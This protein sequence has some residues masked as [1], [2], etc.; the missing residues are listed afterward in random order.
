[1]YLKKI[2]LC[3]FKSFP[4]R[5]EF[6]F[7]PGMT[8]IVGPNG[9]GKSNVVDALKWILGEQ[10]ARSLRGS[11]ML[12]VIFNG[13][14]TR[15]ALGMA[16][17]TL[18]LAEAGGLRP[19]DAAQGGRDPEEVTVTR[20]LYRSG[21]SE[22]LI[23]GGPCRLRDVRDLLAGTGLSTNAYAV[24]EQGRID[25]LIAA[26]PAERR[27]VFEEAAGIGQWKARKVESERRLERVEQNLARLVDIFEEV[28]KRLRGVRWAAA[29]ARRYVEA[30]DE[31]RRLRVRLVSV[32]YRREGRELAAA[33]DAL[34]EVEGRH[35]LA[36]EG[37]S[38]AAE[39]LRRVE[40][41]GQ[42]LQ[43]RHEATQAAMREAGSRSQALEAA[44]AASRRLLERLRSEGER[45][46]A[47]AA[48]ERVLLDEDRERVR[49]AHDG[50]EAA[51]SER[52]EREAALA[53]AESEARGLEEERAELRRVVEGLRRE[54]M[55]L[56]REVA[57]L[58]NERLRCDAEDS[59]LVQRRTRIEERRGRAT[60]EV[61]R[62]SAR[63]EEA[64]TRAAALGDRLAEGERALLDE[65][66]RLQS[67][68]ESLEDARRREAEE[69]ARLAELEAERTALLEL[70]RAGAGLDEGARAV[71]D[72]AAQGRLQ[73][74]LGTV[75]SLVEVAPSHARA[76]EAA[77]GEVARSLV[78][79][80]RAAALAACR[81][82][83]EAGSPQACLLALSPGGRRRS[84]RPPGR[85][86]RR[87]RLGG[88]VRREGRPPRDLSP[89]GVRAAG[90][91]G[92]P[93]VVG[94][95]RDLIRVAP[96][97]G[98]G[99]EAALRGVLGDVWVVA[100]LP[101]AESLSG[102]VRA[103]R[104]VTLEG[105]VL[106][107][108]L[109]VRSGGPGAG[110]LVSRRARLAELEARRPSALEAA[111]AAVDGRAR[112]QAAVAEATRRV[113]ALR[114]EIRQRGAESLA[115]ERDLGRAASRLETEVQSLRL[116]SLEVE[117][118]DCE[119]AALTERRRE[120]LEQLAGVESARETLA[121]ELSQRDARAAA[122]ESAAED[123]GRAVAGL[124]EG[125]AVARG[126]EAASAEAAG[127]AA[128]SAQERQRAVEEAQA[129]AS[130]AAQA[131]EEE[132]ARERSGED[133]LSAATS[134]AREAAS[135]LEGM[136]LEWDAARP[137]LARAHA[138]VEDAEARLGLAGQELAVQRLREREAQV[139]LESLVER[140][141]EELGVD[142][143]SMETGPEDGE[144]DAAALEA[145]ARDL[146]E[147]MARMGSINMDALEELSAL[148]ERCAYLVG[149]RRDLEEARG[150]LLEVIRRAGA[151]CRDNFLATFEQVRSH[152]QE[153]FRK[154]FGGGR[155]DVVL[156]DSEDVLEGGIDITARPPGK[157][158]ASISL[159]SG[160]ERALAAI[161]L[162]FAIFR[163]RPSPFCVL[164]EV[165]A[166]LDESNVYRFTQ[167]VSEFLDL[168]QFLVITHNKNTM[169]AADAIYGVTQDEPGVSR[170]V[171]IQFEARERPKVA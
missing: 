62:L 67:A 128:R 59:A 93:G 65:D 90:A 83:R 20:R 160:G 21:E 38:R 55:D 109:Q 94:A 51:R 73:G 158:P 92:G 15:K 123:L 110:G 153:V 149:Q 163:A 98:P 61:A 25:R 111:G 50:E 36:Q 3:G 16:E 170:K 138:A 26:N 108:G 13:T 68:A 146:E 119:A 129:E 114:E 157:E 132:A 28:E 147:R 144:E 8:A 87:P 113:A 45:A 164:D 81:A 136:A 161:A 120:V 169:A 30:R 125:L 159:L 44:L 77:L 148:E 140:S 74:V 135:A 142:P 10:S 29:K 41:E 152:F 139:R 4:D 34:Q 19:A 40:G 100:D 143:G 63:Q 52:L 150:S 91:L 166:P 134:S 162:L 12:D 151:I 99:L 7:S 156:L 11:A 171:S 107:P 168:S 23:D 116:S 105:H 53:R 101:T 27:A 96:G 145:Q 89:E 66:A 85:H 88:R 48:R 76:L 126:R 133:A 72:W 103:V 71:V 124:R 2:V 22:Y 155:A 121:A 127:R 104:L 106:G 97:A 86:G 42:A 79:R 130:R 167:I 5:T 35:A 165:D 95:A 46:L 102:R 6:E 24:M 1:M 39:S 80:D 54:A 84:R 14:E 49:A 137:A 112:L 154:L 33:R 118:C 17:A 115:V 47:V 43:S 122:S 57:R 75:A 78:V 141:R 32:R 9:C 31:L 64:G 60:A 58:R 56:E 18:T 131:R 69:G 82:L 117:E 37:R 70:D